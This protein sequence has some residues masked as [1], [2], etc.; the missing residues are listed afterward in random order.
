[1]WSVNDVEAS[2]SYAVIDANTGRLLEG[3][4]ANT[5]LPIASLTKVW[6]ALTVLDNVSLDDEITISNAAA[7]QEGSSLY[8]KA[9]E[10][11]TVESLL[12]GLLLQ[13]GND[14]AYALAEHTGGSM[15]GF[16]KLMNEKI[17]L[18]GLENS[19]FTNPSGLHQD[20]HYASALDMAN[21]FRLA[22][23]NDSYTQIASAKTYTPKER[24]VTWR[25][26]HKLLHF[27]KYA[28]A[29]KTGYTKVAGR[30]LVTYFEDNGKKVIVVT[31]N[32]SNDW[33]THSSLAANV[34]RTYDNV[35]VVEK[36]KYR[37]LDKQ[38]IE[39][40][41]DYFLLLK[42]EEKDATKNVL[43]IPRKSSEK[44]PYLWNVTINNEI[45][46]KFNVMKIK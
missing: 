36:G 8:L 41:K 16:T 25:N 15:E 7:T 13:S 33:N 10:V 2:S 26:K 21:M 19:H 29:G 28:V 31:L 32:H 46:L 42:K 44:K 24:S 35:K 3:S 6:T 18:A 43:M 39:V 37:L 40:K 17:Q 30:T 27:N 5:E 9:G 38:I 34:F 20:E 14:A 12:Y 4:N 1:M 45:A 22:L 23:Q 11:W